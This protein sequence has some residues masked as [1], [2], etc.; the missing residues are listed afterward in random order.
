MEVI[1]CFFINPNKEHWANTFIRK[2][3]KYGNSII[4][5]QTQNFV[6][7]PISGVK[8]GFKSYN[9]AVISDWMRVTRI[10]FIYNHL[11]FC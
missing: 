6:G 4:Y 1:C 8:K 3:I 5:L 11:D 10:R 7:I 2:Y 9:L